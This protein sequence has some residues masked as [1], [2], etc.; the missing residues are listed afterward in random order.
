MDFLLSLMNLSY[1]LSTRE[2]ERPHCRSVLRSLHR[3]LHI[4]PNNRFSSFFLA[5]QARI[6][7]HE[8]IKLLNIFLVLMFDF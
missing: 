3:K 1:R 7:S 6:V 2:L 8:P 4:E 5:S